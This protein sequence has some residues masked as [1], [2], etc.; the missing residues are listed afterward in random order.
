REF[1]NEI[2]L[3]GLQVSNCHAQISLKSGAV[4]IEDKG[5][6]NGV[7]VNGVRIT[8]TVSVRFDDVVQIGPFVFEIAPRTVSVYDA[9]AKTRIDAI[10]IE[11]IVPNCSSK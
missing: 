4:V 7:Y 9:R 6:T 3:D 11:K 2:H 5:C 10:G 1:N 8:S